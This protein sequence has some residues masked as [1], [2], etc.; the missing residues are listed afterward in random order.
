MFFEFFSGR[1]TRLSSH[2][3][4]GSSR[5]AAAALSLG[6]LL[7]VVA[8]EASATTFK[9]EVSIAG[10]SRP[11]GEPGPRASLSFRAP[12]GA[13]CGE[14]GL[15]LALSG[16]PGAVE[17]A[18]A[19][20]FDSSGR[21]AGHLV[22]SGKG[23]LSVASG[24]FELPAREARDDLSAALSDESDRPRSALRLA[25]AIGTL[26]LGAGVGVAFLSMRGSGDAGRPLA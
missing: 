9:G 2:P 8:G 23:R 26:F 12:D 15:A 21:V 6:F 7:V 22:L 3:V 24:V 11:S 5:A 1:D 19:T 10:A 20:C 4:G 25:S 17:S 13:S 14:A 18:E 16:V